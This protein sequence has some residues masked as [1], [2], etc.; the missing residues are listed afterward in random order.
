MKKAQASGI[1]FHM[2]PEVKLIKKNKKQSG[3]YKM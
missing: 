3:G 1:T 2:K